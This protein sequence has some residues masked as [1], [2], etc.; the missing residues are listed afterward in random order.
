MARAIRSGVMP[1]LGGGRSILAVVHAANVAEGAILA[2]T[3]DIAG[4]RAYN[5]AND[6]DVTVREFFTLAAHGLGKR[7]RFVPVP[8]WVAKQGLRVFR[9]VDRFALGG[10]F[11]V[12]S[13]GSL[14]FMSRD[15]PFT[16]DRARQELGWNPSV[17]PE[18]GVPAAFR[19]AI[20]KGRAD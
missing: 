14:S 8:I 12:A 6:Y 1:L 9:V 15:N 20:E 5:L 7:V 16:S 2:A 19:W 17:R 3:S 11:A 18:Q 10:K 13:E 4:G